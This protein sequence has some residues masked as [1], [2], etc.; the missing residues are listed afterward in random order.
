MSMT[1]APA[2]TR[3]VA[4]ALADALARAGVKSAY[5][6]PGESVLGLLEA[7]A[8]RHIRVVATRHEGAAAFM[9]EAV[10][11]LTGKP[12]L[13]VAARGP[14]AANLAIG[15]H[16][17]RQ[18]SSPVIAIVGQVARDRRGR[19][20]FQEMDVAAAYGPIVKWA[21]EAE[22][23]QDAVAMIETAI[24]AATRG[25]PGPVVLS[26]PEDVLD[27]PVTFEVPAPARFDP[28]PE[29]DPTLVRKVLHLLADSR[30]PLILAGS[31]VLRARST[32]A[33]VKLAEAIRVPVIAAWR[34]PDAFPNDHPLFLGTSGPGS[35][36][37]VEAR[38]AETDALLVLGCR[39]GEQTT[40]GYRYPA[41]ATRWAHV[42]LEP[43][44]PLGVE[45]GPEIAMAADVGGFLRVARRVLGRAAFE[46][47]SFDARRDANAA[48]RV[49]YEEASRIAEN[50][51]SGT[52]V[53]PSH[54]VS[55]IARVL[56]PETIFTTDAGGFSLWAARGQRYPR[57]GTFLGPTS[58]AMGY[59]L[60]AAIAASLAR[61]G[62]SAVALAGDG[63]FAMLMAELETAVRERAHVVALVF[64]N[65]RYGMIWRNQEERGS[66]AGLATE[67]GKMDFAAIA[68]ACGALGLSVEKD[69][70]F[71]P[72][73]RRALESGR[74]AVLHLA[75]DA[76]WS[77]PDRAPLP[78]SANG[79]EPVSVSGSP[80]RG[81]SEI[82]GEPEAVAPDFASQPGEAVTI[83][84]HARIE[85]E[86]AD[87]GQLA[88]ETSTI[89]TAV[90]VEAEAAIEFESAAEALG[91]TADEAES[92]V[93]AFDEPEQA[94][95]P[96]LEPEPDVATAA[97]TDRASDAELGTADEAAREVELPAAAGAEPGAEPE[98]EAAMEPE[99]AIEPEPVP[100]TE[101]ETEPAAQVA[102]EAGGEPLAE[103]VEQS[104]A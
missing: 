58:G 97:E 23:A 93:E 10:G 77:S 5:T 31:G 29:P 100:D 44:A 22:T 38:L 66:E 48:D 6:V 83:E 9:A 99:A 51:W 64:D 52:G 46:A 8:G 13:C 54:I 103:A 67:L 102:A 28:H 37:T 81:L 35:A 2:A 41:R 57:P 19:E 47:A 80:E 27:E 79:R 59:A 78:T 65:S 55:T 16:T 74:P 75:F 40:F 20:A 104:E 25:R 68:N 34:R 63:G 12:G 14:G 71:E 50:G 36:P 94:A 92:V 17:A 26:V 60:P 70:E 87:E 1:E 45:G 96:T 76:A 88:I 84:P 11:Q 82:A 21:G 56:P 69:D 95:G 4:A 62:R 85:P 89:E 101:S 61:P 32:D 15:L 43:Q 73:L 72:A 30:R 3:T 91:E 42:D 90:S 24:V 33:L 39:L 7:L 53:S 86:S 18:D 98:T 49:A